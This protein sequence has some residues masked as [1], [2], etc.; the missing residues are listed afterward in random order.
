MLC[1]DFSYELD[2]A[3]EDALLDELEELQGSGSL[4]V[5]Y[6][7]S[8]LFPER[9]FQLVIVLRAEPVHIKERLSKR[10]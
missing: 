1:C 8:E 4:V 7:S 3:D 10:G 2:E 9:W 5:D 6:H